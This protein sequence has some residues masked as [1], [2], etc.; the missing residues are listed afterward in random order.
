MAKTPSYLD[1]L[2][3][4]QRAAVVC[5]IRPGKPRRKKPLLINAGPGS[6]KTRTLAACIAY[7]AECGANPDQMM[8]CSFTRKAATELIERVRRLRRMSRGDS[9]GFSLAGTFH[10][11]ALKFLRRFGQEI[12]LRNDF[13]VL[14]KSDAIEFIASIQR[15]LKLPR[16]FPRARDCIGIFSYRMNARMSLAAT[17]E[18]RYIRYRRFKRGLASLLERYEMVKK[19]QNLVDYDDLLF[20]FSRLV[21]HP[22]ARD[23]VRRQIRFVFVD[24][25]QDT[26]RLQWQIIKR[27]TPRG[28]GLTV[29]GDD[30]QAIYGFRAASV[31]NIRRFKR[32]FR[33]GARRVTLSQNYRSTRRIVAATSDIMTSATDDRL[34]KELWSKNERGPQPR[35]I[36]V[37][38]ERAQARYVISHARMLRKRGVAFNNQAVLFRTSR[39]AA[40]LENELAKARIPFVKWGGRALSEKSHVREFIS[41]LRWYENPRSEFDATRVFQ[42]F[43]GIGKARAKALF[44][45]ID[46]L[47]VKHSLR[48]AEVP[49]A[50]RAKWDSLR[51]LIVGAKRSRRTW[52]STIRSLKRWFLT[53]DSRASKE[54]AG[55][56]AD[57]ERFVALGETH[58]SCRAFLSSIL[59]DSAETDLPGNDALILST[60]HSA[61]GHEFRAVTIL[62]VVE[63]CI[64]SNNAQSP[65]AIEEERRILYVGMTR[66]RTFLE[67]IVPQH[68]SL[69]SGVAGDKHQL[70]SRSRFLDG[71]VSRRLRN[72]F[73]GL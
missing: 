8:I 56:A 44:R 17:L 35:L 34:D 29:V 50:A 57:V 63:G 48:V 9:D 70:L 45:Q 4:E 11:I 46:P 30:A 15:Q 19:E 68:V 5:G 49:E 33:R 31:T 67:L 65:E 3:K 62:S 51:R 12:G 71:R 66:A 1:K 58:R 52:P 23:E 61:K 39:E 60:I 53:L 43:P 72:G 36:A 24:E 69:R 47:N 73:G 6:G 13:S 59:V 10:S 54:F 20:H 27:L 40:A 2:N 64:P 37:F 7:T 32:R 41:L 55:R 21:R 18:R 14:G 28:E 16:S 42:K 25:F 38:D 22:F 26:S